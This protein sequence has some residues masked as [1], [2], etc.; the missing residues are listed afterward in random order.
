MRGFALNK[1]TM[2]GSR[3]SFELA[4]VVFG[5]TGAGERS[6]VELE[7]VKRFRTWLDGAQRSDV[8]AACRLLDA[9]LIPS[10][11]HT[12]M[13]DVARLIEAR[14]PE[15]ID[16]MPNLSLHRDHLDRAHQLAQVF[17]GPNLAALVHALREEGARS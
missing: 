16:N 2:S 5:D 6:P 12:G 10:L 4:A 3:F 11:S 17:M 7:A 14:F 1:S 9:E 8:H 15:V 13:L